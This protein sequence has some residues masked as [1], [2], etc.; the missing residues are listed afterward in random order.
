MTI[1]QGNPAASQG[2]AA[3]QGGAD[4]DSEETHQ[5]RLTRNLHELL[6]ELRVAQAG[7][8]ILFGFLLSIAFTE[9]YVRDANAFERATHL[10]AVLF[11]VASVGL[12]TAPAAWHRILFRQGK[13]EEIMRLATRTTIAGLVCLSLAVAA[14][15]L[16]LAEMV[17]GGWAAFVIAGV[18]AA[19]IM[20]LWFAVPMRERAD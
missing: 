6:Q 2:G 9:V 1:E 11:A 13:R 3:G 17:I 19:L 10:I 7:V 12:L 20:L 4:Q 15:V 8:Q 16:L 5:Q 14:S 18:C